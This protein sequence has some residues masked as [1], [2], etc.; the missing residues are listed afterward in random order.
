MSVRA[1]DLRRGMYVKY[2]N[3][4]CLVVDNR[5]VTM[6][7]W[8]SSQVIQFRNL[9]SGQLFEERFRTD[10]TFDEV[11]VEKRP[12][13]YMYTKGDSHV[14]MD[15][16]TYEEVYLPKDLFGELEAFLTENM[17]LQVGLV[18][19][20]PGVV[21]LPNTVELEVIETPP[22]LRGATVTNTLKDATLAGGAKIKV[23][24]FVETG[25][26]VIVDTRTREYLS[27]A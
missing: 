1:I 2:R 10:E 22:L 7:N 16:S 6:G 11:F 18:D 8:R 4:N 27:R 17:E 15:M 5:K 9:V 26:K 23:P 20:I 14:A 25:D 19:G 12:M 21:E 24:P 13:N 3:G